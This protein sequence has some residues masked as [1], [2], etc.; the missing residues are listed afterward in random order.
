[1]Y[2][3]R[4]FTPEV[5][6]GIFQKSHRDLWLVGISNEGLWLVGIERYADRISETA[7]ST[8]KEGGSPAK[9]EKI[10]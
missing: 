7:P 9:E 6:L 8:K 5:E 1:M 10:P 2:L 3:L 4:F